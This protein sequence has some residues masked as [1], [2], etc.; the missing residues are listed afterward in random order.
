MRLK[1][2]RS[3]WASSG[4][5]KRDFRHT[6]QNDYPVRTQAKKDRNKYCGGKVQRPHLL[7]RYRPYDGPPDPE[8][9]QDS[10][11]TRFIYVKCSRCGKTML[12]LRKARDQTIPFHIRAWRIYPYWHE[13][14]VRVVIKPI[15]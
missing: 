7:Y 2:D 12:N 15:A 10:W 14:P 3:S 11:S 4:I 1:E 5:V 9:N 13:V 6:P 8:G